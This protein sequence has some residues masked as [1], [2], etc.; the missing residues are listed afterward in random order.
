MAKSEEASALQEMVGKLEEQRVS[1]AT[2]A[3]SAKRRTGDIERQFDLLE[4]EK[5]GLERYH[6]IFFFHSDLTS[7][8]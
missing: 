7:W 3:E 2:E 4:T 5:L 8:S 1:A 6:F